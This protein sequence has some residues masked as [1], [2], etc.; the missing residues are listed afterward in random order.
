MAVA[1]PA[2][3]PVDPVEVHINHFFDRVVACA[4]HRRATL[5]NAAHEKRQEMAARVPEHERSEQQLLSARVEI[6]R[7]LRENFLR[8]TQERIL[9]EI[10]QK[11]EVLRAPVPDTYLVFRGECQQLEQLI[12][13]VGEIYEEEV[14]VVPRYHDMRP[15]VAVA[16]QGRAP[17]E[18]WNPNGVAIDP[19]TNHIYV[20]EGGI[21]PIFARVSIFSESGEFLNSYTHEHMKLLWGIAIHGNNLYITDCMVHAVFHLKIETD[22]R[23][24]ARLGSRG[25]GIGQFNE[26]RQ[27]SISTNGDV[28]IP[29]RDNDRIQILD[30]SLHPIREVTHPSM[31]IPCDVKLTTEEMYV[32]S[33]EDSPCVHVFNH[34]GHKTRSLITRGNGMQVTLPLFFC[35]DTKKNLIISD[36]FANQIRIFSNEGDLLHTIG[37]HGHQVGMFSGPRGLA[38]TSNLNLVSVSFNDN[39]GLQIFSSL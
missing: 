35:L 19:A 20:A 21:F 30:S 14:P 9:A 3:Q 39:Y 24:V 32:L 18:L 38:L 5:L 7:H 2:P 4:Q 31:H 10:E 13:G 36:D 8:E 29:D 33:K 25:S 28:Y 16:K 17:G 26:P 23:L 22:F 15:T 11:L 6:E 1:F 37:E 27:L 12:E 34:T